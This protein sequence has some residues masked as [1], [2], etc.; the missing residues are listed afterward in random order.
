MSG[1]HTA[2]ASVPFETLDPIQSPPLPL[3]EPSPA[4]SVSERTTTSTVE[5]DPGLTLDILDEPGADYAEDDDVPMSAAER[6]AEQR[7]MKRFRLTHSQTRFLMSEFA[8]QAHPDAAH[9]ERLAREI[10]GLSSRQVQVWF[11]NR[12]A[13]LKRLPNDDR[14]S[15]MRSRA[16][17]EG[18]DTTQALHPRYGEVQSMGRTL[19][20]DASYSPPFEDEGVVPPLTLDCLRRTGGDHAIIT[21]PSTDAS[22]EASLFT[23]PGSA[24]I[25]PRSKRDTC[26][27]SPYSPDS[28]AIS[29]LSGNPFSRS[30][31]PTSGFHTQTRVPSLQLHKTD[32]RT[33]AQSLVSSPK[34]ESQY[35]PRSL[36]FSSYSGAHRPSLTGPQPQEHD[37]DQIS[38]HYTEQRYSVPYS[39]VAQLQGLQPQRQSQARFPRMVTAPELGR[40]QQDV[41]NQAFPIAEPGYL[42]G[43]QSAPLSTPLDFRFSGLNPIIDPLPFDRSNMPSGFDD[44]EPSIP[45]LGSGGNGQNRSSS[46]VQGEQDIRLT[47]GFSDGRRRSLTH[48]ARLDPYQ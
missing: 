8:R 12:R 9:R 15:M 33:E 4:S 32:S 25:S 18:F 3:T 11:Q 21:P 16:L 2:R 38:S 10:P 20:Y 41:T 36:A 37:V 19:A 39:E 47:A 40:R 6:R 44:A 29:P 34:R 48:P 45:R 22:F 5:Q 46:S 26:L 14:E 43:F 35:S 42:A 13:K 7:R 27:Q 28:D 17:P 24:L 31:I 1:F 30:G 23:P